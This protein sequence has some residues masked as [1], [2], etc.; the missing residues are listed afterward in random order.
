MND[1]RIAGIDVHKKML[2]VVVGEWTAEEELVFQRRQF[3]N[4]EAGIHQM[5]DWFVECH[6]REVVM[7]STAQYFALSSALIRRVEVP[8]ALG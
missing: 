8:P 7:E 4:T 6:V 3:D 1:Y 5:R 2:A